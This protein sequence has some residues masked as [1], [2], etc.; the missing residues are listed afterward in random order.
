MKMK[1]M[2]EVRQRKEHRRFRKSQWDLQPANG[3]EFQIK[4]T[5]HCDRRQTEKTERKDWATDGD[6][7]RDRDRERDEFEHAAWPLLC[8]LGP[9]IFWLTACRFFLHRH[10]R[11]RTQTVVVGH[12]GIV[13]VPASLRNTHGCSRAQMPDP[14]SIDALGHRMIARQLPIMSWRRAPKLQAPRNLRGTSEDPP[15][16]SSAPPHTKCRRVIMTL[17]LDALQRMDL[18][19]HL[20]SGRESGDEASSEKEMEHWH[21]QKRR[22]S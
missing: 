21:A 20:S 18:P 1:L 17:L 22:Q 10:F 3:G 9:S 15:H 14:G 8:L 12:D 2:M 6:R 4:L 13:K 16:H 7:K 5:C 11:R 19:V